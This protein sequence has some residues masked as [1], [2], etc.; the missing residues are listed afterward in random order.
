MQTKIKKKENFI[1][2]SL[3]CSWTEMSRNRFDDEFT[4]HVISS[5]SVQIFGSNT[6]AFSNFFNAEIQLCRDWSVAPSEIIFP[7]KIEH[8]VNGDLI[9]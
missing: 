1:N 6:L 4:M 9:A 7:T 3:A 2:Q 8:L 5:A